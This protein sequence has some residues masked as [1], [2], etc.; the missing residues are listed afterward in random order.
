MTEPAQPT[1]QTE[2]LTCDSAQS[3]MDS[4]ISQSTA[5]PIRIMI[6]DDGTGVG[7]VLVEFRHACLQLRRQ[8][9]CLF[10]A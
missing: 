4:G 8:S 6:A 5:E 3:R 9:Q 2:E 7:A 1:N 10:S